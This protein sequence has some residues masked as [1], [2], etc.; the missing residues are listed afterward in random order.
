MTISVKVTN[1]IETLGYI[2]SNRQN[3]RTVT[4]DKLKLL[5]WT[6]QF[7]L[8]KD[9]FLQP[10][11]EPQRVAE[12]NVISKMGALNVRLDKDNWYENNARKVRDNCLP[13]QR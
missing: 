7:G 2:T 5:K 8:L 13:N 6:H 9:K 10:V 3:A 4:K 1:G 11:D 12:C